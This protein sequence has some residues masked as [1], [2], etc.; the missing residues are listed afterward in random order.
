MPS[1]D[2]LY[3]GRKGRGFKNPSYFCK[4]KDLR[5]ML[6]DERVI[7]L[8]YTMMFLTHSNVALKIEKF[9]RARENKIEFA[10]DYGN[11]NA[12]YVNEKINVLDDYFQEMLNPDFD[13]SFESSEKAIFELENQSESDFQVVEKVCDSVENPKKKKGLSNTVKADLSFV[14]QFNVDKNAKR[15]SRNNLMACNNSDTRSEFACNNAKNAFCNLYDVDMNDLFVFDDVS[16][17]KSQVSKMPFRKK[18]NA[19]LNMHYRSK[20]KKSLPRN[21]FKWLP[22][23]QLLAEPIAK[24]IPRVKRQIDKMS[25][26]TNLQ[27]PIFKWHMTG[28]LALLTNFVEKFLGTVC[29]VNND[30]AIIA[31]Y[32][33]IIIG[34]MTIKRVYYVE[35]LV[36]N[37][38]S[39]GQF[40]DKGLKVAFESL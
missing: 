1:K 39:V 26:T 14:N 33:D 19:S 22:K 36:H 34:S 21:V 31:G 25:R 5:P 27:G 11:L 12:S 3:N 23:L 4:A 2:K 8:G 37:L 29:F 16:I 35:G 7:N 9:K 13:K 38:F 40:C 20:S 18:P 24:W 10:Y 28:N 6:Y 30:F 32:E 17:R 15:Y